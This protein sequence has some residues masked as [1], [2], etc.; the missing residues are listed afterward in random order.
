MRHLPTQ[1]HRG[2][3]GDVEFMNDLFGNFAVAMLTGIFCVYAVMVLLFHDFAQPF[4]VLTALPLAAGGALG[5]L[6][7]FSMNLSLATLIGL[8]ML[9]GIVSKNSILLVEY[10]IAA[11]DHRGLSR[12]EAILDACHRSEEHT[13]ELQALMRI[14]Y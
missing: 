4:T 10:A 2:E 7:V 14:S 8:L 6:V 11:R 13:S 9:I 1:V 3:G 12:T 5:A